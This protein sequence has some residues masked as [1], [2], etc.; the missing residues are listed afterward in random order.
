[1]LF[2]KDTTTPRVSEGNISDEDTLVE[3]EENDIYEEDNYDIINNIK[4]DGSNIK[5]SNPSTSYEKPLVFE[6]EFGTENTQLTN[7]RTPIQSTRPAKTKHSNCS[8]Y[9]QF[10]MKKKQKKQE[11]KYLED[12]LKIERKKVTILQQSTKVPVQ[13]NT[14]DMLFFQSLLPYF[15][16]LNDIQKL[17]VRNQYQNILINEL[18]SGQ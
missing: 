13:E 17:R 11:D 12:L 14:E 15:K 5:I 3:L 18:S 4:N 8:D 9:S 2:L 7:L 6:S 1:M 16:K 10:P